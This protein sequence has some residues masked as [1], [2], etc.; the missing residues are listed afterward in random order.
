MK[1][2][3]LIVNKKNKF[4]AKLPYL[5]N[6]FIAKYIYIDNKIIAL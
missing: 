6:K 4:I 5:G 3:F 1:H 2:Y